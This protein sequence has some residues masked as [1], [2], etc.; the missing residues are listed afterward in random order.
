MKKISYWGVVGLPLLSISPVWSAPIAPPTAKTVAKPIVK[1]ATKPTAKSPVKPVANVAAQPVAAQPV[2]AKSSSLERLPNGITFIAR[3]DKIAPRAAIS[4]VLRVGAADETPQTAGWRRLLVNAM[5]RG[6]PKGYESSVTGLEATEALPRA[7]EKVGGT[8]GATVGDDFVEIFVVGDAEKAPELLDFALAFW[9]NPRLSDADI[10]AARERTQNQIEADDLDTAGKTQ[11]AL[12]SQLFRDARGELSAYGLS[13]FGT[14]AS[15]ASLS[16]EKIRAFHAQKLV[17]AR[18]TA[19]ATG[20][21]DAAALREKLKNQPALLPRD[22]APPSFARPKAGSPAL[23]VRELPVPSAWVFVSYPL[24]GNTQ[25]DAATLRVLAAALGDAKDAR[26]PARLLKSRPLGS[27]PSAISVAAQFIPRRYGGELVLYSQTGPQNVERVK[28]ALLD[29]I[30]RLRDAPL[31]N[32]ELQSAKTY[33]RGT[34][35]I[36]RLGLRERAFQT[37]LAPALGG[38]LDTTFPT[39]LQSVT[40]AQIQ[41]AAKKYLQAYAVALVMPGE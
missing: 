1:P 4:L 19:A 7:A 36:E 5:L 41:A 39:R 14:T 11:A 38:P 13:D 22:A 31:S 28:N 35:S 30:R 27:A 16:N 6:V 21:F 15:L 40:S 24:A 23:V 20:N 12:R 2:A 9:K 17:S 29:E 10:D 33:A 18:L 25:N 3:P 8:L 34:W 32:S 26:L 37:A